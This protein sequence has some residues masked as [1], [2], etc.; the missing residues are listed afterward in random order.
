MAAPG[1]AE[2]PVPP[3][4]R[5]PVIATLGSAA[6]LLPAYAGRLPTASAPRRR[7]PG[8]LSVPLAG[9]AASLTWLAVT[10]GWRLAAGGTA[11][12]RWTLPL[13]GCAVAAV[14]VTAAWRR[15]RRPDDGG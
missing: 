9:L 12:A 8:W 5:L 15:R 3:A 4:T 6:V 10:A 14:V 7:T 13:T 1:A 2:V 11:P